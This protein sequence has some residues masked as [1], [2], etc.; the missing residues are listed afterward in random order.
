LAD[1]HALLRISKAQ[2][3]AAIFW[4]E[5]VEQD[6]VILPAFVKAPPPPGEFKTWTEYE[7]FHSHTHLQD[8][9]RWDVPDRHDAALW[10]DR[11]DVASAPFAAAWVLAQQMGQMWLAKL[12]RDFPAY[13]FRVYVT[14]LDDPIVQFH[15]VRAGDHRGSAM[16]P[17]PTP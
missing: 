4:P 3:I 10:L 6:G 9:F 11:P 16:K 15:R 12:R 8:V 5:F 2:R 7:R 14:K 1:G 13:R 17:R